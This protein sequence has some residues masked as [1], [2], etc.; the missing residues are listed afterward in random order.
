MVNEKS[1]SLLNVGAEL[2]KISSRPIPKRGQ[3]KVAVLLVVAH[4]I[5]SVF[6]P[7]HH[8]HVAP[9]RQV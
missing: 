7:H 9:R 4:S 2:R 8:L 6:T 3:V 1:G 5:S